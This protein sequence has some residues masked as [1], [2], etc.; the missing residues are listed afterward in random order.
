[1]VGEVGPRSSSVEGVDGDGSVAGDGSVKDDG[2]QDE[3]N[4]TEDAD[5]NHVYD[6][7][8]AAWLMDMVRPDHDPTTPST[9][10][11]EGKPNQ[12]AGKIGDPQKS[13]LTSP[14]GHTGSGSV[15]RLSEMKKHVVESGGGGG[16]GENR[17]LKADGD[18]AA[19]GKE[20]FRTVAAELQ[21]PFCPIG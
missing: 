17:G 16:D 5:A 10:G 19:D 3:D 9:A 12:R 15:P 7:H 1:M 14:P 21:P 11:G 8:T 2:V 18:A 4:P 20:P 13:P 6:H